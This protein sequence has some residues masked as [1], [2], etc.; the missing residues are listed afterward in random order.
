MV[1]VRFYVS[2][3]IYSM[4]LQPMRSIMPEKSCCLILNTYFEVLLLFW[5]QTVFK[6]MLEYFVKVH[7]DLGFWA[8]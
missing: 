2:F 7:R 3:D 8:L 5:T 4:L 6:Q 1:L